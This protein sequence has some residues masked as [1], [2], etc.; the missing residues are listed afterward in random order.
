MID[1]YKTAKI[2]FGTS[3][4]MDYTVITISTALEMPKRIFAVLYVSIM[5][6]TRIS[7]TVGLTKP[8]FLHLYL[9]F[10]Y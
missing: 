10:F 4:G 7:Y 3:R 1:T 2:L 6:L 9:Q 5:G 8:Q